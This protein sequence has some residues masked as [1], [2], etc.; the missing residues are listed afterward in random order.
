MLERATACLDSGARLS[1]RCARRASRSNRSLSSNFW[2]H[3]ASELDLLPWAAACNSQAAIDVHDTHQRYR[4]R[5]TS[6]DENITNSNP[7][8]G[9][10]L[11]FLYPP[12]ALA[13]LRRTNNRHMEKWEKRNERR[14]PRGFV[15]ATRRYSSK[16][17][18]ASQNSEEEP[19]SKVGEEE[20]DDAS[21]VSAGQSHHSKLENA[22][23]ETDANTS[24][25]GEDTR[26]VQNDD[27]H[28]ELDISGSE[29]ETWE[30][31]PALGPEREAASSAKQLRTLLDS[32]ADE[33]ELN[34]SEKSLEQTKIVWALW[35]RLSPDDRTRIGLKTSVLKWLSTQSNEAAE[36]YCL[37]LYDSIPTDQRSLKVYMAALPAFMRSNLYG[38]A[39]QAHA[40]ALERLEN[41]YEVSLWLGSTAIENGMWELA[42]GVK[43]QLDAKHTG[44]SNAWIN[45]IFWKHVAKT[46]NLLP[47]AISLSKH[48]R[49]LHQAD[50]ISNEFQDF[51]FEV[52]KQ[53]IVQEFVVSNFRRSK[54]SKGARARRSLRDGSIR[55]LIGR[56]QLTSQDPPQFFRDLL[57]KLVKSSSDVDYF[58][59]H[60]T[61][62]YLYRQLRAMPGVVPS[63]NFLSILTRRVFELYDLEPRATEGPT[64]ISPSSLEE[65]WAKFYGK[66]SSD[67]YDWMMSYFALRGNPER[68]HYYSDRRLAEHPP[69]PEHEGALRANV[70]VYARRRE[71]KPAL[72]AFESIKSIL[73]A[74]GK[75]PSIRCWNTLLHA[76][77]RADD[78]EGALK[79]LDLLLETGLKPTIRS[80]HPITELYAE[81]GDVEGVQSLM[82]Q[83]DELCATPRRTELYG[84]L[85]TAYLNS[86]RYTIA[87]HVLR[88]LI[89]KVKAKEVEGTLTY[90]FNMLLVDLALRRKL[91]HITKVYQWMTEENVQ[92][93]ANTYA[94]LIQSLVSQNKPDVAWRLL[95]KV[96]PEQRL[97][98]QAFHY[99][100]VMMGFVQRNGHQIAIDIYKRMLSRHI[101]PTVGTDAVLARATG[102]LSTKQ[103]LQHPESKLET[104]VHPAGDIVDQLQEIFDDPAARLAEKAPQHYSPL[105]DGTPRALLFS[106]LMFAYGETRSLEAVE[107]LIARYRQADHRSREDASEPLPLSVLRTAMPIYR[108]ARRWQEVERC[109]E[110][111]REQSQEVTRMPPRP[112]LSAKLE[113]EEAPDILQ[114]RLPETNEESSTP[115]GS[116]AETSQNNTTK[117]HSIFSP[118]LRYILSRPLHDYITALAS[119]SRYSDMI[120]TVSSV[121]SQGYALESSTWNHFIDKLIQPSPPLALL[122][123]RLVERYLTPFFPGWKPGREVSSRLQHRIGVQNIR[124]IYRHPR[125]LIPKYPML[126]RLAAALLEVRRT[127]LLQGSSRKARLKN[128]AGLAKHVGTVKQIRQ[129]APKTLY[130]VQSMPRRDDK[131]QSALLRRQFS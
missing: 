118:D 4:A 32:K 130:I 123:F 29:N 120:S 49:M 45:L 91:T 35:N 64:S 112:L 27:S 16:S 40:E 76:H 93:D 36:T 81:R 58:A 86:S 43:Q 106:Q 14:L 1:I 107:E 73:A 23:E 116:Q 50:A 74:T 19:R 69:H 15:H 96:M 131:W 117:G 128:Q 111:A 84:S 17:T 85:M 82:E 109:W 103:S 56:V 8:E 60:K 83:Y 42:S 63:E 34:D 38:L 5:Q 89:E 46:R 12:Q 44:E 67:T 2:N 59:A 66:V 24:T 7:T 100:I 75:S 11:D 92:P 31:D 39:E 54:R 108:Y 21:H 95:D 78:I 13:L 98:A 87:E 18:K 70:Y 6:K 80:I 53:A 22:R 65:D 88:D 101:K 41:G 25:D 57:W 3:G 122:A 102:F 26:H 47:K 129:L 94:A 48:Y 125:Q 114:L 127:D 110:L 126:V 28:S 51:S 119:Q 97:K 9:P 55:Y 62:S 113:R 33:A 105:T 99:S 104:S 61:V 10:F 68:V 71:I 72:E 30:L 121:L 77:S 20:E 52:F 115:D 79:T 124:A 90:C 37:E